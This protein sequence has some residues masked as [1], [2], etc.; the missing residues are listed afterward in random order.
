MLQRIPYLHTIENCIVNKAE[1]YFYAISPYSGFSDTTKFGM[2][3]Q[4]QIFQSDSSESDKII[5][6]YKLFGTNIVDGTSKKITIG[7]N[8]YIQYKFA[9]TYT[10]QNVISEKNSNFK[11][12][13]MGLNNG[14]PAS[15]RVMLAGN[16]SFQTILKPKLKII[17]TKIQ[18]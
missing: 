15:D 7:G 9:V 5:A 3:P 10:I 1:L 16:S 12:K 8:T 4:L 18:K 13:I 2:I 17:Y 6:D 11:F 14:F